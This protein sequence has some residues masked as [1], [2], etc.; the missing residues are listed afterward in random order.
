MAR[1]VPLTLDIKRRILH[2][3]RPQVVSGK[4]VLVILPAYNAAET[5]EASIRSIIEQT[6]ENWSL[7]VVDDCS[8]DDSREIA[9]SL[10]RDQDKV[11]V[12]Q[13]D[14]NV[15]TYRAINLG[16]AHFKDVDW[17]YFVCQGADDVSHPNRL[18]E[19]VSTA[20]FSAHDLHFLC[21][22]TRRVNLDDGTV[23]GTGSGMGIALI[24]REAFETL[25]YFVD[26]RFA[27]DN[28]YR[29]RVRRWQQLEGKRARIYKT[30]RIYYTAYMTGS[31]LIT[32]IPL[33]GKLRNDFNRKAQQRLDEAV[34]VSDLNISYD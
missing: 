28:E 18:A 11:H 33:R 10:A 22:R 6:H 34:A 2:L 26:T 30:R 7:V 12:L 14:S 21:C 24:S 13:T 19:M 17:Q 1:K 23:R 25:G 29:M 5:L 16:L 20:A 8:T 31:N 3:V 9:Q 27:G 4:H 32:T 15:G